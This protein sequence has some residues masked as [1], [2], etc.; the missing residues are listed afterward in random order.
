[1]GVWVR[2]VEDGV[3]DDG[4]GGKCED[5]RSTEVVLVRVDTDNDGQDT[6]YDIRRDTARGVSS[7]SFDLRW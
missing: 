5:E 4:E 7:V 2:G 1:M 3:A 6:R